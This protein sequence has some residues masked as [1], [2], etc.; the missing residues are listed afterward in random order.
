MPTLKE[1][2][3]RSTSGLHT[4]AG[5]PGLLVVGSERSGGFVS[6]P[7][8][9]LRSAVDVT[10]PNSGTDREQP[11]NP[12][13]RLELIVVWTGIGVIIAISIIAFYMLWLKTT[14]GS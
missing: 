3:K 7:L 13:R 10:E 11:C 14:S 6:V 12:T 8:Q 1:V 4:G 5:A 2:L 9:A